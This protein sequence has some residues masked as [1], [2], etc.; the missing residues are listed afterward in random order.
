MTRDYRL[1]GLSLLF[2]GLG[3][4][5]FLFFQPLYLAQLGAQPVQIGAVLGLAAGA[6][7]VSHIPAGY[8][9]DRF[10]PRGLLVAGWLGGAMAATLMFAA[11]NL[12]WFSAGLVAYSLTG[13]VLA[14]LNRYLT[15]SRGKQTV[16]RALTGISAIYSAGAVL[17]PMIGGLLAGRLGLRAIYAAPGLHRPDA[18][19]DVL[20]VRRPAAYPQLP[21][22]RAQCESAADRP[23]RLARLCGGN[24]R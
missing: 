17:S 5:L 13:F 4:G 9:T 22:R 14:P 23:A 21:A 18:V 3:D 6:L 2:W 10:G 1:V 12:F 24:H 8:L 20:H 15:E 16:E 7:A 11:A 19:R